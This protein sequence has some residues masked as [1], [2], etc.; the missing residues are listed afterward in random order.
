MPALSLRPLHNVGNFEMTTITFADTMFGR[1]ISAMDSCFEQALGRCA[2][3]TAGERFEM[4]THSHLVGLSGVEI[5]G[6]TSNCCAASIRCVATLRIS[7]SRW[8]R[9]RRTGSFRIGKLACAHAYAWL[10][11]A[12]IA[13]AHT[14]TPF[15]FLKLRLL[16]QPSATAAVVEQRHT[17]S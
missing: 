2:C 11:N 6:T 16:S 17:S 12:V 13:T 1:T 7:T 8:P 4:A 9:S 15:K 10:H 5:S 3:M 14:I